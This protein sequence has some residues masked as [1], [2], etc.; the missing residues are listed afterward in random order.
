MLSLALVLNGIAPKHQFNERNSIRLI[1]GKNQTNRDQKSNLLFLQRHNQ[2]Q[3]FR[4][5]L[6]KNW[7]KALERH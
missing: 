7:Q 3:K 4:I 1:N 6:F 5:K 2:S